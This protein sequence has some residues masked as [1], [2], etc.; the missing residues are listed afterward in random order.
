[1]ETPENILLI[2]IAFLLAGF[3]KGVI[4]L[5]LPTISLAILTT[6]FGLI[7]AMGLMI[8]PSLITNLWLTIQGGGLLKISYRFWTMMLAVIFG[9]WI[10]GRILVTNDVIILTKIFS[11]IYFKWC[12]YDSVYQSKKTHG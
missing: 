3:V 5:G 6:G 9:I 2:V 4:G 11:A 1:M 8:I 7:S 10:G 12:P